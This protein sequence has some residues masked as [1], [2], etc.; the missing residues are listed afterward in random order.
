MVGVSPRHLKLCRRP[1]YAPQVR[2]TRGRPQIFR[3]PTLSP[4]SN[5][6]ASPVCTNCRP[7]IE[8][9]ELDRHDG[10]DQYVGLVRC[11]GATSC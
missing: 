6:A 11:E 3:R 2:M 4:S 10:V 8:R 7:S 1:T 5:P 9:L